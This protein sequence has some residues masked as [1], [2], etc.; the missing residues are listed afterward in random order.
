[1]I[2]REDPQERQTRER[3]QA[4]D[5]AYRKYLLAFADRN[6]K[7]IMSMPAIHGYQAQKTDDGWRIVLL[8]HRSKPPIFDDFMGVLEG[9]ANMAKKKNPKYTI[10]FTT[11]RE[12]KP[13][14]A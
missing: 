3:L 7:F 11:V 13:E 4:E 5:D 8:M 12:P 6:L 10:A 14:P 9:R 1:M 2:E